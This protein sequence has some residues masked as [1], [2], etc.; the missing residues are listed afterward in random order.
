LSFRLSF[1]DL[2]SFLSLDGTLLL[3]GV[4]FLSLDGSLLLDPS[5]PEVVPFDRLFSSFLSPDGSLLLG[6]S[7]LPLDFVN[8][9]LLED[10]LLRFSESALSPLP[11]LLVLD[12][13][14]SRRTFCGL[15]ITSKC[16][17]EW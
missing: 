13:P 2:P 4:L 5:L 11:L 3:L 17:G 16:P 15:F 12:F 9:L 6:L 14:L 8:L 1:D 7:F 10:F